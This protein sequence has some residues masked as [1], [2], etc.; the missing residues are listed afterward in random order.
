[1]AFEGI[2]PAVTTPFTADDQVDVA[3]LKENIEKLI[4]AGVHGFVATG[5]MGEAGSLTREE[6]ALVVRSVVEAA[7]GRVPVTVGVSSGSARQSLEYA[8]DGKAAGAQYV[9]S[10]PPLGYRADP[11]EVVAFYAELATCGLPIMAYNNPEASGVDL[12]A[13]LI[14]R[15]YEEVDAV[16]AVKECSGD[17]RRIPALLHLEG[18]LEVVVGGDDWA[19]EG[20]AAGAIGW[21]T[22]VGVLA[23]AETV[24]LYE[25]VQA[26]DLARARDVYRRLLPVAR[27][28]MTSKLVQ[29]FKAAQDAVGFN[30][31][32][33]RAPRL[34]LKADEV[35]ALDDA[36]AI[37]RQPATV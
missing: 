2:T 11:D 30:G 12:P 23:P 26:N 35:A 4:E 7:A 14:A 25:A 37:L 15:I 9:M 27:F 29:Y 31:G 21:I 28:D 22:G 32:P 10:L 24:E 6:R 18:D 8:A 3:A 33:T 19:L 17:T 5:T 36:L 20:F 13:S 34:P 16:I 1:M